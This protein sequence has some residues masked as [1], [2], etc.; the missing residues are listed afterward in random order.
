MHFER[1]RRID[2][3][4]IVRQAR[5]HEGLG[6]RCD[7]ALLERDRLAVVELETVRRLELRVRGDH[8]H[9]A[10]LCQLREPARET[11]DNAVL[12]VYEFGGVN[13][14]GAEHDAVIRHRRRIVDYFCGMQ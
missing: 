10:L 5:Q 7:D 9:L 4:R 13:L 6:A 14:R 11:A 12:P 2:D 3:A 8:T 1:A